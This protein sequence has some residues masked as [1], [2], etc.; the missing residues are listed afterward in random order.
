[1]AERSKSG[2]QFG[3]ARF[4][5]ATLRFHLPPRVFGLLSRVFG[6]LSCVFGLLPR[7]FGL[8]ARVFGLLSRVHSWNAGNVLNGHDPDLETP[9]ER[10]PSQGRPLSTALERSPG[11]LASVRSHC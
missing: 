6:L 2:L 9:D 10:R 4:R 11:S 5:R 3:D 1:L 8:L 7:V